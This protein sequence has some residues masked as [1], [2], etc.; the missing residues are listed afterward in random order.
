MSHLRHL[1][2]FLIAVGLLAP[3]HAFAQSECASD[4]DCPEGTLCQGGVC[5]EGEGEEEF[6]GECGSFFEC[7]EGIGCEEPSCAAECLESLDGEAREAF[8]ALFACLA[9]SG[10]D[11]DD[12]ECVQGACAEQIGE[13]ALACGLD[14]DIEDD[15]VELVEECVDLF[16]CLEG[17]CGEDFGF[18]C[19]LSCAERA[20]EPARGPA[21]EAFE[22]AANS[23][24]D[25]EDD[26][27]IEETCE[28]EFEGLINFCEGDD[29]GEG[30]EDDEEQEGGDP[31]NGAFNNDPG[32]DDGDGGGDGA[33]GSLDSSCAAVGGPGQINLAALLLLGLLVVVRRRR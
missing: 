11:P 33:G 5:I 30:G 23:G 32:V 15:E 17:E 4:A 29:D 21:L 12:D 19:A 24:C 6:G 18:E 9:D 27:C 3:A 22:C 1:P 20:E 16:T 26:D 10:C 31:E 25:V 28:D 14:E 7:V 2:S 8:E 13:T